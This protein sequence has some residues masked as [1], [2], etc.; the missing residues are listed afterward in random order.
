M[1]LFKNG[2]LI[3]AL[4][5]A[6]GL[7][8]CGDDDDDAVTPD[9]STMGP[10]GSTGDG[11]T[12]GG[13]GGTGGGDGGTGGGNATP[14]G[15]GV[16]VCVEKCEADIDCVDKVNSDE[17]A[18]ALRRCAFEE[19][20]VTQACLD[21]DDCG[22]LGAALS[23]ADIC[24]NDDDCASS[25]G[26]R[27]VELSDSNFGR[28]VVEVNSADDC[29]TDGD[30]AEE[31]AETVKEFA[32]GDGDEDGEVENVIYCAKTRWS[33]V[34]SFGTNSCVRGCA[35]TEEDD[36]AV[37]EGCS[38][39]A[40][41]CNNGT[42]ECFSDDNNDSCEDQTNGLVVCGSNGTCECTDD[43]DGDA[44]TDDDSCEDQLGG[45]VV[46]GSN[47]T[48]ECTDDEDGDANTDDDSC[49]GNGPGRSV[50][51]DGVCGCEDDDD[52]NEANEG[53]GTGS[54]SCDSSTGQCGCG[55]LDECVSE[56]V[57]TAFL[58]TELVCGPASFS[59]EE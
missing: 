32:I 44:N 19:R 39:V 7:A 13:D 37:D 24:L 52:C 12:G 46:C 36:D 53:N 56:A 8:G 9:G 33:C 21:D 3:C 18:L 27:C 40:P 23:S 47:G 26:D 45:L 31:K 55:G 54:L 15:V 14:V 49:E 43:E 30:N 51:N 57:E 58:G 1:N 4:I 11:G 10:D 38:A 28:C 29:D 48:C 34:E 42:C 25:A 59:L 6:G 41:T 5:A 17:F 16:D 50:C 20:C 35:D 2:L 22:A